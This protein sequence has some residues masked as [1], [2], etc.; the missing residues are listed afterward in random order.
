MYSILGMKEGLSLRV[1]ILKDGFTKLLC[2]QKSPFTLLDSF[3]RL[4]EPFRRH[5]QSAPL[6]MGRLHR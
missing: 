5:Q 2:F 3:T 1:Q 6:V 4:V